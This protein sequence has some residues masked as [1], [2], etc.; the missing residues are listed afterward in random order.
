MCDK[1]YRKQNIEYQRLLL[2]QL[3]ILANEIK[4]WRMT[5][6]ISHRESVAEFMRST[7]LCGWQY[8]LQRGVLLFPNFV[9]RFWHRFK[10]D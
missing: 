1:N 6:S 4:A 10:G 2:E 9:K 5:S 7:D 3:K 8:S